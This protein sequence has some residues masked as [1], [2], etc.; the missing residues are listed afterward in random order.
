MT[1]TRFTAGRLPAV[2]VVKWPPNSR[3][4]TRCLVIRTVQRPSSRRAPGCST[5]SSVRWHTA[6][7]R[8]M[9]A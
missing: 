6:A 4:P 2:D 8:L 9:A 1:L 7:S 3:S 5:L